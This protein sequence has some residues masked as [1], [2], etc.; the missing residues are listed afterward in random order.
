MCVCVVECVCVL[1]MRGGPMA[2]FQQAG[3][4]AYRSLSRFRSELCA[5]LDALSLSVL[6]GSLC[7]CSPHSL[8]SLLFSSL[9]HIH[10]LTLSLSLS[11]SLLLSCLSRLPSLSLVPSPCPR[12]YLRPCPCPRLS[13]FLRIPPSHHEEIILAAEHHRRHLGRR[14]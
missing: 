12:P 10:T 2:V 11:H 7:F 8:S 4:H 3:S 5:Y 13:L 14:C 6:F 9:L 1:G